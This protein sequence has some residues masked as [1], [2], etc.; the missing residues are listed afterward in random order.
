MGFGD[1]LARVLASVNGDED[2]GRARGH[3]ISMSETLADLER[4]DRERARSWR[5]HVRERALAEQALALGYL[6]RAEETGEEP[7]SRI[8]ASAL[9]DPPESLRI[10][11]AVRHVSQSAGERIRLA[12]LARR[13]RGAEKPATAPDV[14]SPAPVAENAPAG[15]GNA[16]RAAPAK[17]P[18]PPA[19]K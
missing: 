3:R 10:F 7:P 19:V 5:A 15:G 13:R 6:R 2:G 8:A 14:P 9:F 18:R 12:A 11:G 16:V 1:D 17:P 4:Q